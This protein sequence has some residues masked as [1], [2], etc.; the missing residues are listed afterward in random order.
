MNLR[1]DA[2]TQ[3]ETCTFIWKKEE[4]ISM[5][6]RILK[7]L[8]AAGMISLLAAG[9]TAS[10]SAAAENADVMI[11][12]AYCTLAEE[13]AVDLQKGIVEQAEEYGYTLV[14]A[15]Y[16]LDLS[17]AVDDFD[18]FISMGCDAIILFPY[19]DDV[20]EAVSNKAKE[21]GIKIITVDSNINQNVDTYVA[22]DNVLGGY[23]AA[24]YGLEAIGGKGKVLMI[25]P[26]PGMTSLEDR[27]EGFEKALAE[28]PDIEVIEQ[29]DAGTEARAGYAQTVENALNANPDVALVLAN[30]GDCALGAL[31][32]V[33]LYP[34]KYADIK[35]VG[36]DATPEQITALKE[37]RQIICSYAQYP[38]VM[39]TTAVDSIK[40][41]LEGGTVEPE[42]RTGGGI[43]DYENVDEFEATGMVSEE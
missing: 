31:S 5:K 12:A 13:F 25:T 16:E 21:Q 18:N 30:C 26:A 4:M 19:G 24:K 40:T 23:E 34:D 36:Y 14:E 35:I 11:G 6:N 8:I 41:L 39:G 29:M 38:Y 27:C 2:K 28:Y 43:V 17:K 42:I 1:D 10:V 22:T 15:D 9:M 20:F 3:Y 32:T 33:E 37:N 7:Q